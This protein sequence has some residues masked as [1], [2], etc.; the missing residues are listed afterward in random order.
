MK[1]LKN[2]IALTLLVAAITSSFAFTPFKNGKVIMII[3]IEV[4]NFSEWKKTFDGGAPIRQKAG[5]KV[6]SICSA[7][8]NENKITIIEEAE[9]AQSADN[10]LSMLRSKQ[11]SGDIS[12]LEVKVLDKVE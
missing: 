1:N 10:F 4:Q 5:I 2:K 11:K 6:V 12:K 7:F 3:S 8:D 9:N